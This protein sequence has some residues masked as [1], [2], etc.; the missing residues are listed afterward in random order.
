MIKQKNK[1]PAGKKIDEELDLSEYVGN[2][3]NGQN[4]FTRYELQSVVYVDTSQE[5]EQDHQY[6]TFTKRS[7][8]NDKIKVWLQF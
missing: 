4:Q 6:I 1:L 3:I 2:E 7:F 5:V 8:L